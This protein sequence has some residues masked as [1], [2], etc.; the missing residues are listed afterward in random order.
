[1]KTEEIRKDE[2]SVEAMATQIAVGIYQSQKMIDLAEKATLVSEH[3]GEYR[4]IEQYVALFAVDTAQ[5][6]KKYSAETS[7]EI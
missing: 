5:W 2:I 4:T 3:D 1:M 7:T 6:I